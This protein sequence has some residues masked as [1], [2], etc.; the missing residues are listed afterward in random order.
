M[1]ELADD[2]ARCRSVNPSSVFSNTAG[3]RDKQPAPPPR[4]ADCKL[5]PRPAPRPRRRKPTGRSSAGPSRPGARGP[6]PSPTCSPPAWSGVSR[7]TRPPRRSTAA[8]SSS[9]TRCWPRSVPGSPTDSR[10]A[11]S[12]S[13]GST[14][15]ATPFVDLGRPRDRQRRPALR[16]QLRLDHEAGQRQGRRRHRVLRQHLLQRPLV[17]RPAPLSTNP[18]VPSQNRAGRDLSLPR[19]PIAAFRSRSSSAV[20]GRWRGAAPGSAFVV[21]SARG[22]ADLVVGDL[23]HE[24]VLVGDAP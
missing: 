18:Q 1:I 13:A 23:V 5:T 2:A 8:R 10:S 12:P 24:A 11:R 20:A 4:P 9:S 22:D 19:P 15:T 14:P 7:D 17:P 6:A 3:F 21:V 16:E